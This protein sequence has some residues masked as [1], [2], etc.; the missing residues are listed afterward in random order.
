MNHTSLPI[1]AAIDIGTTKICAIIA[2][3]NEYG[4]IE[5]L[6]VGKA[7]S[8]GVT[9]GVISNIDKTVFAIEEAVR[10]AE[11]KSGISVKNVY[12][13]IA[14]Q[15]IKSMRHKGYLMRDHNSPEIAQ[16]DVDRLVLDM[17]KMVLPPG[18]EIIHVLPQ[19]FTIDG[20]S[21]IKDPIGMSGV[22]LEADFHVITGQTTAIRNIH[23]CIAKAGLNLVG[24]TLE[25]L[26]SAAA[27]LNSDELEAGIALVDI[28]GGTTDIAIFQEG[29]IRHTSVIPLGG[30]VI[31]EDIKEGCM[32]MRD[33]A[34]RLKVKFGIALTSEAQDNAIVSIP[35]LRGREPK[36]ISLKNLAHI[37]QARM[38]EILECI[39]LEIRKSGYENKLIGGIVLT[40]GGA[41]LKHLNF[42]CE[43]VT[44]LDTR[45]GQPTE[46]LINGRGEVNDPLYAT[47]I[48]LA[49]KALENPISTSEPKQ[50][51]N[52]PLYQANN[53]NNNT[54]TNQSYNDQNNYEHAHSNNEMEMNEER[55]FESKSWLGN[56]LRK[57]REWL[58]GDTG[59]FR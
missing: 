10:E 19:E 21:G 1:V 8:P 4:K 44:G 41:R 36:E 37:I 47:G 3:K 42:L 20:E 24:L 50:E 23:R 26:A 39:Y 22:K 58:E 31:T 59:D 38:E 17:Q 29:I 55:E 15:H 2:K 45:V 48:G 11:R 51:D 30:H 32:V 12:A 27:V 53:N 14:G 54:A 57:S 28:G 25:P 16:R 5:I 52:N 46:H 35:G 7:N 9:R 56:F 43:Y 18:D 49:I 40:G 6:G 33:Q 13:G 34:E